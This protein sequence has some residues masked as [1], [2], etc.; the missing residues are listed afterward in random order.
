MWPEKGLCEV[1]GWELVIPT[2]SA[3]QV[4]FYCFKPHPEVLGA[5]CGMPGMETWWVV[6]KASAISCA[7]VLAPAGR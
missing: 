5:T 7:V 4:I 2:V 6:S 1:S 3:P